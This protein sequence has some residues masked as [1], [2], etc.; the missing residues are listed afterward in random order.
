MLPEITLP[1]IFSVAYVLL[2][3]LVNM[4]CAG[5]DE[6]LPSSEGGM[7]AEMIDLPENAVSIEQAQSLILVTLTDT[8]FNELQ[9]D[10]LMEQGYTPRPYQYFLSGLNQQYGLKR[11]ADWPLT[12]LG[13]RCLV[14]ES[15][16]GLGWQDVAARL[17]SDPRI[18]TIQ[19]LQLFRALGTEYN[20]P[21]IDLQ[22]GLQAMQ[23]PSSHRW[24]TGNGIKVAVID[25]GLDT[26][27]TELNTQVY[28]TNNLVNKDT[29]A[30]QTD[31]HGTAV[32]GVIAASANNGTGIVGVAPDAKILGLKACW[33]ESANFPDAVC[34]SF[35]LAKALNFA[36]SKK[37]DIINL[38][39]AGP[40]DPLLERLVK[41]AITQEIV[42]VAAADPS[43][44]AEFPAYIDRVIS[45]GQM[46]ERY[47]GKAKHHG[48]TAPGQKILSARPNNQYDFFSGSS[49]SAAHVSGLVALI[50][51]RKPHL[52]ASEIQ[53]LL[54]STTQ[55][56]GE[57]KRGTKNNSPS[58]NACL[59]LARLINSQNLVSWCN[60]QNL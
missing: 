41:K 21:Y 13:I 54:Q 58:I 24:A 19:P 49:I 11:V 39:L 18:E 1:R 59:A 6:R 26:Q 56:A 17:G 32:A 29:K 30:F 37:V 31:L 9:K 50:K 46:N 14:F 60:N 15:S 4:G 33:Q 55:I 48:L 10:P 34:S 22:N 40:K 23:V 5:V 25:T 45:V 53:S 2:V 27:H 36:I 16:R 38:S 51:E 44:T 3:I 52:P 35:T 12:S 47:R 8:A 20:D 28:E 43:G 42:I 57:K 7:S